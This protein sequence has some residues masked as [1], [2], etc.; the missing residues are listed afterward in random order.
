M[1]NMIT[2]ENYELMVPYAKE[3]MELYDKRRTRGVYFSSTKKNKLKEIHQHITG[4]KTCSTCSNQWMYNMGKWFAEYKEEEHL[5]EI[6]EK[7]KQTRKRKPK[8][9]SNETK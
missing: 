1:I 7:V 5:P 9:E 6:Q 3:L 2:K 4:K 8:K